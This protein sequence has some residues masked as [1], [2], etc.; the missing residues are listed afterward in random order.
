MG[1]I[2]AELCDFQI[3]LASERYIPRII[4]STEAWKPE[5]KKYFDMKKY[6]H[7]IQFTTLGDES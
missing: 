4:S 3:R 1:P 5:G 2:D 6:S 7:T